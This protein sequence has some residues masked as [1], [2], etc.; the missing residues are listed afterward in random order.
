MKEV[1]IKFQPDGEIGNVE[2]L[3]ELVLHSPHALSPPTAAG[4]QN[5]RAVPD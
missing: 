4:A 1:E 2:A 3:K 5:E